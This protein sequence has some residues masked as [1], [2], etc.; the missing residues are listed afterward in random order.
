MWF[1]S[2]CKKLI[3]HSGTSIQIATI[4]GVTKMPTKIGGVDI[5]PSLIQTAGDILQIL[6]WLQYTLC[7]NIQQ[8]KRIK[9]STSIITEVLLRQNE[10]CRQIAFF[11]ILCLTAT[12]SPT[13][14]EKVLADWIASTL[15]YTG[16]SDG[17]AVSR[18]EDRVRGILPGLQID[19]HE[20]QVPTSTDE[21][22]VVEIERRLVSN[23]SI[24][25]EEFPYLQITIDEKHYFDISKSIIYLTE[26]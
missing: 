13:K 9:A 7:Q 14:F 24:A 20:L 4:E 26:E 3:K 17:F 1:F 18:S 8:L 6:D 5:K 19:T 2:P 21:V 10:H 22:S 25:K 15:P 11:S 23:L 16:E 12:N